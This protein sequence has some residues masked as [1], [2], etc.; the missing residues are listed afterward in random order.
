MMSRHQLE[1]KVLALKRISVKSKFMRH[2]LKEEEERL[3]RRVSN[4]CN[5]LRLDDDSNDVDEEVEEEEEDDD[6]PFYNHRS[7]FRDGIRGRQSMFVLC[8]NESSTFDLQERDVL[9]TFADELRMKDAAT[10]AKYA[11]VIYQSLRVLVDD[12]FTSDE[13]MTLHSADT[14]IR[15]LDTLYQ[16][17]YTLEK[18][19]CERAMLCY[20]NFVNGI[21]QSPYAIIIDEET[22]SVVLTIRGTLSVDDM[23]IDFQYNPVSL[24]KAGKVCGFAG[25]KHFCHAGFLT[26]CKWLYNDI[27]EKKVLKTLF[28][29][30]SPYKDYPLIVCGH[31]LGA[32]CAAVLSV[33]LRPMYH[34]LKCFAYCPPGAVFNENMC[35]ICDHFI[36]CIVRQDDLS[37]YQ[38]NV[39]FLLFVLQSMC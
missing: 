20:A 36:T 5:L 18:I 22:K 31:S 26:R 8:A 7:A 23:V 19:G 9:T 32:G 4:I 17:D 33:M 11:Q 16:E 6:D 34:S 28:S 21:A 3:G 25:E 24:K 13:H 38:T 12:E 35:K 15:E 2:M 27:K 37:E 1:E 10:Y 39:C 29:D 14:F 30:S